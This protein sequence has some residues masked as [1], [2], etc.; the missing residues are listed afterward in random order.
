MFLL[1]GYYLN[2]LT[3]RLLPVGRM[4]VCNTWKTK[5]PV[6]PLG[7]NG[8]G[9]RNICLL[10][11]RD[12][13]LTEELYPSGLSPRP[14][15]RWHKLF[16][17]GRTMILGYRGCCKCSFFT[18]ESV[19][20]HQQVGSLRTIWVTRWCVS[21]GY[22]LTSAQGFSSGEFSSFVHSFGAFSFL[23]QGPRC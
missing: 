20:I 10:Y 21:H 8:Y 6:S 1:T 4:C 22:S 18:L 19:P 12:G 16:G 5:V 17:F 23:Q 15:V 3:D 2:L 11:Y 9:G 14:M 13:L 7:Q